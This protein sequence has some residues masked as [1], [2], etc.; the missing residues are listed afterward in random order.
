MKERNLTFDIARGVGIILM[1]MNHSLLST[2][3]GIY[4]WVNSFYM[5]MFFIISGYFFK[6]GVPWR[7]FL[8][9]KSKR[10]LVPYLLWSL[11]HLVV[12]LLMGKA[13]IE[14]RMTKQQAILGVFWNNNVYFPIA[15]ALWFL[16][17]LFG[18][19]IIGKFLIEK[20]LIWL[21]LIIMVVGLYIN[22]F[23]PF[24]FDATLI[25]QAFVVSG[26][27][28]KRFLER[29]EW[30]KRNVLY[31]FIGLL[32]VLI[33]VA[34]AKING[35]VNMRECTYGCF[36]FLFAVTGV[37]GSLGVLCLAK[38]I[39]GY[40]DKLIVKNINAC[41]AYVG[42]ASMCYLCLNQLLITIFQHLLPKEN[43]L[44]HLITCFITLALLTFGNFLT[45]VLNLKWVFGE[46]KRQEK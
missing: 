22:P 19:L 24:S 43:V 13:G 3:I 8:V 14:L 1:I 25:G 35:S 4:N 45:G 42:K 17:A 41:F 23:L 37:F 29:K 31:L 15:G 46:Y 44:I 39:Y 30:V 40:N 6:V 38:F 34:L 21:S 5:P 12:W 9:D 16:T 28:L 36:P 27:L 33:T 32:G 18:A 2:D 20:K 7:R 11:F 10:L 26:Y